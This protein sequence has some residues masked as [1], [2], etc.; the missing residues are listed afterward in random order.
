[1][2]AWCIWI[3]KKDKGGQPGMHEKARVRKCPFDPMLNY[4]KVDEYPFM[5]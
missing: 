1:M 3:L 4:E 5:E 2:H